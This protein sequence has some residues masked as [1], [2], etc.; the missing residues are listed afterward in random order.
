MTTTTT[1][2]QG[3]LAAGFSGVILAPGEPGY[4]E[5]R[6]IHN[7]L[8]D[9]HPALIARCR[10][11][12]DVVDAVNFAR[13]S[14]LEVSVR[15]GGHNVAGKAVT[16]GGLMIDLSSMK[17]VH[18]DRERRTVR[19]QGG[20]TVRELDRANGV[21]GLATPSGVVSSTG[22]AG[23]T[24]GGGLAWLMGRYGMAIDNLLSAEVVLASGDV[25]TA[26]DDAD[27]DLFWAI[28]GGG[29]NFGVVT[30]FEFRGH[31]VAT[32]LRGPVVHPA[33][34]ATEVL[35]FYRDFAAAASDE[36]GAQAAFIHAPDG[37]GAKLCGVSICH[38]GQ[39]AGRAEADLRP[40]R[41]F[42]SPAADLIERVP[43][44]A[45]NTS[46]DG[47]FE[48]GML[49]YWKSAFF[50]DLSDAAIAVLADAY[51]HAP[52]DK[53]VVVIERFGGEAAR[54]EPTATAYPH[55]EPGYN[56]L[57][58]SQWTDPA[59][60]D[61]GIAWART[62]FEALAPHMADRAYTNYLPADDHDRVRQAFGVNFDRL[63]ELKR[64]YDRHNLFRLNQN[65][66]PA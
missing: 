49:C 63:V 13:E 66:D 39:D 61:A 6:K 5:T 23:L 45:A 17:G 29:G 7:G 55:R 64:R 22:I 27:R 40:L 57:L 36:L 46:A 8:I 48:R 10:G 37:S 24:L 28:R 31:E 43:Y 60:S 20:V 21:F 59:D 62:T 11:T 14:G 44:P 26:S 56:L 30:S 51:Q 58:I 34:A 47:L 41:E 19:A 53:C 12:A 33:E 50:S 32:V 42:G 54:V 15:G 2:S 18:V 38:C 4:D 3:L 35:A 9:K 1:G 65:I 25:V 16:E 52:S